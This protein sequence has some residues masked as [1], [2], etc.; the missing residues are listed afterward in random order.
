MEEP[1]S[2]VG[3]VEGEVFSEEG[4]IAVGDGACEWF[5]MRG[6]ACRFRA[7]VVET[8]GWES[9]EDDVRGYEVD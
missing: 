4:E 6:K 3:I 9:A 7:F 5:E 1:G 2:V 8:L